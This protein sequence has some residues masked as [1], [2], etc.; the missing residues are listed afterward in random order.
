MR[1]LTLLPLL[2]VV[3]ASWAQAAAPAPQK[4]DRELDYAEQLFRRGGE[5]TAREAAQICSRKNTVEAVEV[6]LEVFNTDG[7]GPAG[8]WSAHYRDIVWEEL[9]NITNPYA[10]AR[11]E[12]ELKK[13]KRAWV[14]AW[15]AQA[16]GIYGEQDWAPTLIKSLRD[17]D[18]EVRA[19]AALALGKLDLSATGPATLKAEKALIKV[20]HGKTPMERANAWITLA[21][22]MPE[23]WVPQFLG[24]IEG[25]AKDEDGGARCA[26][27]GALPAIAPE[28]VESTSAL[29]LGDEDWR[30]RLQAVDH[31]GVARSKTAVD[32]LIG[33]TG[34]GRPTVALRAVGYLQAL[35][36]QKY[37]QTGGWASWWQQNRETFVFPEGDALEAPTTGGDETVAVYNGIQVTS[38]HVAFLIDKSQEMEQQL[39]SAGS[40]K[41]LFAHKQLAE[42]LAKLSEEVVFNVYTY[43]LEV[44]VFNKKG[45]VPLTE[46]NLK[47]AL[48][49][50]EKQNV[51]NAKDIWQVLEMVISD[52][53][54]DTIYLLSSGE[55]DTGK[56]VH[57][58]RVTEHLIDLNR[59]HKVTVHT[60]AYTDNGWYREQLEK[61][62]EAGNG[63]FTAFD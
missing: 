31:L 12:L 63:E 58:N 61:I 28:E 43:Q 39:K 30:V 17:K 45:P 5:P 41:D 55:P 33:A 10:R 57:W 27:L 38:D 59:F 29:A 4:G 50:T 37:R 46:K 54:I 51:G 42:V 22:L 40:I 56:Y 25:R 47:K 6:L 19:A 11:V 15:C 18:A 26:M 32:R 23:K 9:P 34:D 13:G 20:S 24:A 62:A 8:L 21:T 3:L 52:P 16:L 14:R 44:E 7:V 49:F 48:E 1:S 2:L 60:I 36:G 35:T 53:E